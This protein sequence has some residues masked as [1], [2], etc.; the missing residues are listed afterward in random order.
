[1]IYERTIM[2][3]TAYTPASSEAIHSTPALSWSVIGENLESSFALADE[4]VEESD[5]VGAHQREPR[6]SR[7]D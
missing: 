7:R 4:G 5:M 6:L 3:K 1:L 2:D